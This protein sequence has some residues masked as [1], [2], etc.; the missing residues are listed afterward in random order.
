M[1][2]AISNKVL[3]PYALGKIQKA[4]YKIQKQYIK[5]VFVSVKKL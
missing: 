5:F 4:I 3:N 1:H 2:I